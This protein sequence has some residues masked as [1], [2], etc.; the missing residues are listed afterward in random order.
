MPRIA[1]PQRPVD[2]IGIVGQIDLDPKKPRLERAEDLLDEAG[3]LLAA[4]HPCRGSAARMSGI[5]K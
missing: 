4:R 5:R 1:E 2:R 3:E